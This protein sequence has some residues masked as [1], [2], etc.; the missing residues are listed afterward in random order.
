VTIETV[1]GSG[2]PVVRGGAHDAGDGSLMRRRHILAGLLLA[3]ATPRAA[4]TQQTGKVPRI[5]FLS[6]QSSPDLARQLEA[7]RQ[8]LRELGYVEGQT[9]AIEHRFAEGRPERLPALAAELVR[10]KVDVIVTGAS[11]APEVAKQTTSTIPIVF[12]AISGDPVAE[13]VVSSLARPGGNIT[14]LAGMNPEVVGKQLELLK[15]VAPKISGVA[16]LQNPS[17][18]GHPFVL[19]QAEGAARALGLQLH[20][21]QAGSP[22]EIDAA[23]AAMRGQR[24][25]GIFVLRDPQFLGQRTQIAALA[26]KSRLPAVYGIQGGGGGGRPHGL[27]GKPSPDV[28]ACR[29]LRG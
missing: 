10:L 21:V 24:V 8:G 14:G 15:E 11:P 16:V 26:A 20:I 5:G 12:A 28:P 1:A 25:G 17:N 23:F 22:A 13:G 27:W 4:E 2:D 9:I 3:L 6:G 29:D 7:F 19:R 18:H